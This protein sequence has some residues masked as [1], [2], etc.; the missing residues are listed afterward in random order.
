MVSLAGSELPRRAK[1][2]SLL[3]AF[4][5]QAGFVL[6]RERLLERIW[7]GEF[8]D[9]TRTVDVHILRLRE[10]LALAGATGSIETVRSVGYRLREYA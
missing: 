5:E 7:A 2:F 1:E 3:D 4:A 6:S 8:D 9:D 10:K